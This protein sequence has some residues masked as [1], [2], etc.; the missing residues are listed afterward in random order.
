[1]HRLLCMIFSALLFFIIGTSS[2]WCEDC[3]PCLKGLFSSQPLVGESGKSGLFFGENG[4]PGIAQ[5][6]NGGDGL[7]RPGKG[8]NSIISPGSGG[9]GVFGNGSDGTSTFGYLT[10]KM[11]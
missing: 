7:I 3:C 10:K 1:M 6:G 9:R 11:Q 8:G 2:S 4:R 5:G